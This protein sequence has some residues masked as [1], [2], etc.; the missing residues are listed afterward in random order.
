MAHVAF[1]KSTNVTMPTL[2]DD[3]IAYIV[4]VAYIADKISSSNSNNSKHLD[5]HVI[6]TGRS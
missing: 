3:G 5:L 6:R 1:H 4:D 2:Y